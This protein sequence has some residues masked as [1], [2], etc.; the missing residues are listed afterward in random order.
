MKGRNVRQWSI[1]RDI[2]L[3]EQ[4][5]PLKERGGGMEKDIIKWFIN[6]KAWL[7]QLK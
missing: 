2:C 1:V 6:D 3:H 7:D 4:H 5:F